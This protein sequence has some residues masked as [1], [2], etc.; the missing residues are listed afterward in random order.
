MTTADL[1]SEVS[2][3]FPEI[4]ERESLDWPAL[5][6]PASILVAFMTYLRDEQGFD[7]LTDVSGVDWDK[8]RPRFSSV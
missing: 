7:V 3:R 5:N 4:T 6:V 1:L 2:A 8:D